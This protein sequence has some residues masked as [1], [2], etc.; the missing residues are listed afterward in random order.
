MPERNDF[1][2]ASVIVCLHLYG[3]APRQSDCEEVHV[4]P[5][6]RIFIRAMSNRPNLFLF[7]FIELFNNLHTEPMEH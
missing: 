4:P 3:N 2:G 5:E 1:I 7:P 6:P